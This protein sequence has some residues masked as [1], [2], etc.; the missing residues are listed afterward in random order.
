VCLS[1]FPQVS[2]AVKPV[3]K[4]VDWS[5]QGYWVNRLAVSETEM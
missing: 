4:L 1:G 2:E 5:E 3:L